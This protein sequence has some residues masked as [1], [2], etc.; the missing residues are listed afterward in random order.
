V[1]ATAVAS[2]IDL[3]ISGAPVYLAENKGLAISEESWLK[4]SRL[5][6]AES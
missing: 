6:L 4:N 2:T 3:R 5:V 1:T